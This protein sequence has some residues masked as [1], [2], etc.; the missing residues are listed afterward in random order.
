MANVT[1]TKKKLGIILVVVF[2]AGVITAPKTTNE[3]VETK[4]VVKEV[5]VE[6]DLSD[7]KALKAVDDQGFTIAAE[8]MTL[9]SEG[10]QAVTRLDADEMDRVA[11]QLN[12]NTEKITDLASQRQILL[13]KL[14]Y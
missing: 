12:K 4:E 11:K 5:E 9:C 7:W 3:V 2:F 1:M 13:T 6:K 14:G 8:N 10:F